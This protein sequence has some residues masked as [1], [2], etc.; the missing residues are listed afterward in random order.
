M[1]KGTVDP[2]PSNKNTLQSRIQIFKKRIAQDYQNHNYWHPHNGLFEGKM[3]LQQLLSKCLEWSDS[4]P[5]LGN[6]T[7][8]LLT[9]KNQ[10]FSDI[11]LDVSDI[12]GFVFCFWKMF[13]VRMIVLQIQ[14]SWNRTN[15][16]GK[17]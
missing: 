10:S 1:I 7:L 2:P 9:K 11:K 6:S 5:V 15:Y 13:C 16:W 4:F 8:D 17:I 14:I 12:F 3:I